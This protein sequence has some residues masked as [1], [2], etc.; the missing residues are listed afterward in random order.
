M[1]AVE[2]IDSGLMPA[3]QVF[4][5]MPIDARPTTKKERPVY[6]HTFSTPI[7]IPGR[8]N[9]TVLLFGKPVL[10]FAYGDSA[11]CQIP[12]YVPD[13]LQLAQTSDQD[14]QMVAEA[15]YGAWYKAQPDNLW[16]Q[17]NPQTQAFV[18]QLYLQK[19]P[20]YPKN[21]PRHCFQVARFVVHTPVG[22][23][24]APQ[25]DTEKALSI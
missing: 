25:T 22:E 8:G 4:L 17:L 10:S 18:V 2:I 15:A 24:P 13:R 23:T 5:N 9:A 14:R 1:L 20:R 6:D 3:R 12:V 19:G 16:V 11:G 7:Q 21:H